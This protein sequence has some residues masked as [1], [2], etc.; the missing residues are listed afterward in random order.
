MPSVSR[1]TPIAVRPSLFPASSLVG[2]CLGLALTANAQMPQPRLQTLFPAGATRGSNVVMRAQGTD[3][4]EAT[5]LWFADPRLRAT[6]HAGEANAFELTLPTDLPAGW[7]EA[8]LQGRFGLSNPRLVEVGTLPEAV[9]PSTNTTV[10]AA[11][12]APLDTV[13]N[14]RIA[15]NT[16]S[17]FRFRASPGQRLVARVVA[18]ELDSRLVPDLLA[19]DA[20]GKELA[21]GRRLNVLPITVPAD[22][23]LVLRLNDQTYRGGDEYVYR[24]LVQSAPWV[25]FTVP[26]VLR[27]GQSQS[28]TLYGWGLPQGQ[29]SRLASR[30]GF[31]WEERRVEVTVPADAA[32]V[33]PA[34]A[35]FRLPAGAA[36]G[37]ARW[38]WPGNSSESTTP[39]LPLVFQLSDSPVFTVGAGTNTWVEVTPPCEVGGLFPPRGRRGGVRFQAR[40][41]EVYWLELSAERLGFPSDPWA[42]VQRVTRN[43]QGAE[44]YAD[45]VELNELDTNLGGR[46]LDTTS[47]DAA[48]R[49]QAPEDGTYRVVVR[50]LFQASRD[51]AGYPYRLSLRRESPSFALL[52]YPQPPPRL[53]DNDRQIHLWSVALR[54]GE[55][56]PVRLVAWR[57]DG[58]GGAVD[59]RVEGLPPGVTASPARIVAG[60][61]ATSVLL[62]AAEDAPQG[63]AAPRI[64]GKAK[65]GDQEVERA[66]SAGSASWAVTDWD[67]ERGSGRLATSLP[68][69]VIE[70]ETAP[71]RVAFAADTLE[72]V[73]GTKTNVTLRLTRDPEFSA[74]FTAKLQ[75]PAEADKFKEISFAEKATNTVVELNLAD[76]KLPAGEHFVWA[77]GVA[78]VKYRNNPQALA[79]AEA[80]LKAVETELAAAS[81]E[82]R[83][84]VEEKKKA[85]EA[86]KKTAQE[87]ANP[88]DVTTAVYS[89]PL[90]LIVQPAP[91]A[92][93]PEKK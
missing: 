10:G 16:V 55:T 52:A 70:A 62:T 41:G 21:V 22:G 76:A 26:S 71:V 27:R 23:T 66:A 42:L 63:A 85:A 93:A 34:V 31:T 81:A 84:A 67:N 12:D 46:D 7:Y 1:S 45:V 5:G 54:R 78:T 89:R 73:A 49:F 56:R 51:A 6:P 69:S 50:D 15:A 87:R 37:A 35:L 30:A 47:R 40:K 44:S 13:L 32:E 11:W 75:G 39:P 90:R 60:Q 20:R 24:L 79:A 74:A 53:N 91:A 72:M 86:R 36:L 48:G 3:L 88:R 61:G 9:V 38:N 18:R 80:E 2:L 92:A 83:P 57:T 8:R 43:D 82:A 33:I 25:E 14:G 58:F 29:A 65:I 19:S 28:V 17:W 4:D 77:Q 64:L 59:L 68:V